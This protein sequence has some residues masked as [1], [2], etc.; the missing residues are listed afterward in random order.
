[1]SKRAGIGLMTAALLLFGSVALA[2][3]KAIQDGNDSS[4]ADGGIDIKTASHGHTPTGKL[5]HKITTYDVIGDMEQACL[6][7]T[8][9]AEE[10]YS[11]GFGVYN[12]DDKQT[13]SLT[14]SRPDNKTIIF[15]FKKS[16][17]GNPESY[18]WRVE[19]GNYCSPENC[20]RAPNTGSVR[21]PL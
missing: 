18:K 5:K 14:E 10:Y 6:F 9:S 15:K 11:C 7:I 19:A 17:I 4:D 8:T 2:N 3:T 12:S 13:G 16:A 21:H 1:M 20:D